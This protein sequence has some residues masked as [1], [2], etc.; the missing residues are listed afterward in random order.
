MP[1]KG[2]R[3]HDFGVFSLNE[4]ERVLL[5]SGVVV[6]LGV[7]AF[8]TLL[9]LIQRRGEVV[10]RDALIRLVWGDWK[11]S[12]N[13]LDQQIGKVREALGH[14][15]H[16]RGYIET[17]PGVGY[18]FTEDV[19]ERVEVGAAPSGDSR[20][21]VAGQKRRAR[22]TILLCV[23]LPSAALLVLSF[24][25]GH[26]HPG[27]VRYVA[28]TNDGKEKQ[29]PLLSDGRR[30]IFEERFGDRMKGRQ[31]SFDRRRASPFEHSGT[32]YRLA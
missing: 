14:N 21:A 15:S 18:R 3:F 27:V 23:V 12:A 26:E 29:G 31:H 7:K 10:E 13:N 5:K 19:T 2:K 11:V 6:P 4:T 24:L 16:N 1:E 28:L 30:L 25:V 9:A 22:M 20:Q 17:I 8:D 32:V